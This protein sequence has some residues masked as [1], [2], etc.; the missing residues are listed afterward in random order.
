MNYLIKPQKK[1]Q[2][3]DIGQAAIIL[4]HGY[5][6]NE[7]DLFALADHLPDQYTIISLQ[8]PICLGMDS[9]C[10]FDIRWG[11]TRF[12]ADHREV[13]SAIQS[14]EEFL[15]SKEKSLNIDLSQSLLLGFSQGAILAYALSIKKTSAIQ[16][17][18]R[19]Q[20]GMAAG[21]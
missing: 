15:T 17:R 9:Y 6:S 18:Y 19:V 14:V 4:L 20:R 11:E 21:L 13:Q 12:S 3:S 7:K 10:W 1:K 16:K 2:P 8:A 5:G